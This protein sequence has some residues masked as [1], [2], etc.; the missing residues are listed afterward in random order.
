MTPADR[1]SIAVVAA[2]SLIAGAAAPA[3]AADDSKVKAANNQIET[4]AKKIG[5]DVGA[6]LGC[7]L[8]RGQPAVDACDEAMRSRLPAEIRAEAA[9]KKG[10]E[11]FELTRYG[12]AVRAYGVAVRL[13]PDYAVAYTNLGFSLSRLERWQ[14]ACVAYEHALRLT[15]DD[16]DAHYNLGVALVMLGRPGAALREFR[17]TVELAPMDAD[18]HYNMGLALNSLGRHA[19]AVQ[20]YREA[21]RVR[22]DYADAWGNLGLTANLI[23]QYRESAD[24]FERAKALLPAYFDSRPRQ[25][26]A[27]EASRRDGALYRSVGS[28]R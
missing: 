27:F 4:G 9:H 13:K 19:E 7:A 20:A 16:V 14:E 17:E 18:A 6:F 1:T 28:P 10:V 23:G 12:D 26:E 5:A 22:P 8:L 2:L 25:R 11:L 21:V 24:A 3:V 15:P